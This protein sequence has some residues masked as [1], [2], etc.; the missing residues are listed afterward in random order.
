[1]DSHQV[2]EDSLLLLQILVLLNYHGDCEVLKRFFRED[3]QPHEC[4]AP[5]LHSTFEGCFLSFAFPATA[6]G[7][8][9]AQSRGSIKSWGRPPA[10]MPSLSG[11]VSVGLVAV[12]VLAL[13]S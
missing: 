13:T 6:P 11:S 9:L 8:R 5:I 4:L 10:T 3:S 1:M 12:V 7:E 2:H